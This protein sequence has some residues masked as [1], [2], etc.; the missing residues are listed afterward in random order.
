M[1]LDFMAHLLKNAAERQCGSYSRVVTRVNCVSD[2]AG[3]LPLFRIVNE[4]NPDRQTARGERAVCLS[5]ACGDPLRTFLA[6]RA[7]QTFWRAPHLLAPVGYP[8]SSRV[9]SV[10]ASDIRGKLRSRRWSAVLE[11]SNR[12]GAL[13]VREQTILARHCYQ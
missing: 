1:F 8:L 9:P 2:A 6:A 11:I 7:R 5:D 13:C 4:M 3:L 10:A 12:H